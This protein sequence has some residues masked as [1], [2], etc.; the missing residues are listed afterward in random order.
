VAAIVAENIVEDVKEMAADVKEM[1]VDVL[2]EGVDLSQ[3][4]DAMKKANAVLEA[5]AGTSL[6]DVRVNSR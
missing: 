1:A 3:F 5:V 2:S 4:Q 6:E